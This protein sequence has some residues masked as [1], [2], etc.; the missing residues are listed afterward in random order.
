MWTPSNSNLFH[1]L[2]PEKQ[3]FGTIIQIFYHG[4]DDATQAILNAGGIFLYKTPNEAYQLLEDRVLLKLDWSKDIKAKT[5]RKTIAFA[6]GTDNFKPMEKIEA[7]T[8][9]IDSQFKEIKEKMKDIGKTYDPPVNP[10]DK[11]SII[12]DDSKDEADEAKKDEEP[13]S[14]KK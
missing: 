9:K 3:K 14:S 8:T 10:N 5:L 11:T 7:L 4:L 6:E 13:S 12:H 1:H 2:S